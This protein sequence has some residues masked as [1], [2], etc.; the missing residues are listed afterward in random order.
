MAQ[1]ANR[2][3]AISGCEQVQQVCARNYSITSSADGM[4]RVVPPF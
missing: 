4:L 2:R 1:R 3:V